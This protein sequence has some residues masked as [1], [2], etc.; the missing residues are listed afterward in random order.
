MLG[1]AH[2]DDATFNEKGL[3]IWK[4]HGEEAVSLELSQLHYHDTFEPLDPDTLSA[5]DKQQALESHLFLKE[6]QDS[7]FTGCMVAGSDHQHGYIDK[8]DASSPT[9]HL[10]SVLLSATIDA[11]EGCDVAIVNA[12][13]VFVQMCL[14]QD[15]NKCIMVLQ[16]HLAELMLQ[17]AP[18]V[19]GPHAHCNKKGELVIYV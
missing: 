3:K 18:D 2:H 5:Q 12:P 13:N 4:K 9:A 6:K 16:G 8:E 1:C 15:S 11:K 10:K 14:K 7:T 17:V 19:Y